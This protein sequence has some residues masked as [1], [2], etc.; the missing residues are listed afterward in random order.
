MMRNNK[1]K[2]PLPIL[3]LKEIDNTIYNKPY[4]YTIPS[5]I[6]SELPYP[7]SL[8][9]FAKSCPVDNSFN[10]FDNDTV[11]ECNHASEIGCPLYILKFNDFESFA[12]VKDV[13]LFEIGQANSKHIT[14]D[15]LKDIVDNFYILKNY[16]QVPMAVLGHDEKQELLKKSGLPAAGWLNNLKQVGKRLVGDFIDV[17][18]TVADLL[19]KGAYK[20][21][22]IEIYPNLEYNGENFKTVL[23]RIAFLGF[24]IPKIKGLG[25]ILA[26]YSEDSETRSNNNLITFFVE[27]L[28]MKLQRFKYDGFSESNTF[29]LDDVITSQTAKGKIIEMSKNTMTVELEADNFFS[30]GEEFT[31]E[32]GAKGTFA[33]SLIPEP[34]SKDFDIISEAVMK[35]IGCTKNDIISAIANATSFGQLSAKNKEILQLGWPKIHGKE[36]EKFKATSSYP[37]PT[38]QPEKMSEN[39]LLKLEKYQEFERENNNLRSTLEQQQSIIDSQTNRIKMIEDERS[40]ELSVSHL[41]DIQRFSESL[42]EK[43]VSAAIFDDSSFRPFILSLDWKKTLKFSEN[44]ELT[45]FDQFKELFSEI[46]DLARENKLIIPLDKVP[47][48]DAEKVEVTGY[49]PD[50]VNLDIKIRKYAEDNKVS[51]DEAYSVIL[52]EETKKNRK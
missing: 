9:E 47:E 51:Y 5:E 44:K 19:A 16:H 40:K 27:D 23:R 2:F 43:G 10:N 18:K 21:K 4:P 32:K 17:P 3:K 1:Q 35:K 48:S 46:V 37:Y 29:G 41:E 11:L 49:D 52:H 50:G 22:S 36:I 15:M 12:E 28:D 42:K 7:K 34:Y 25:D 13:Q 30:E 24:D 14:L 26:R 38:Q 45:F 31:N 39:D 33:D 8:C 20:N 6:F